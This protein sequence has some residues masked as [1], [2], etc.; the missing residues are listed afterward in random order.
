MCLFNH[1]QLLNL[2]S[3]KGKLINNYTS[4]QVKKNLYTK[5]KMNNHTIKND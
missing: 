5:G 4:K 2:L 1:T 3:F